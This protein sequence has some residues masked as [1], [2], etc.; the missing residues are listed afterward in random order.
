MTT[1]AE[2]IRSGLPEMREAA[3]S[4]MLSTC[5][6][7]RVLGVGDDGAGGVRPEL[8]SPPVYEGKCRVK[9]FRAYE[10]VRDIGAVGTVINQRYDIHIPVGIGP[11][12]VGDFVTLLACE[13]NPL[14]TGNV[15]RVAGPHETTLQTAQRVLA[16]HAPLGITMD[17]GA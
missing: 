2:D 8:L 15:Y 5:R 9:S 16:D 11:V 10:E 17:G 3:E 7:D 14:L 1:F 13:E 12:Q 6:I 4:L